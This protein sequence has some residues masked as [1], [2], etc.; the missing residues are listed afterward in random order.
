MQGIYVVSQKDI[1][2]EPEKEDPI[3]ISSFPIDSHDCQRIATADGAVVNEGTI[4]P[5]RM[6]GRRHGYPYQVPYRSILPKPQECDNL[7]VPVALSCTHVAIS[8]IRVEPTWMIL[9]QSAGIA[10][11]LA[12]GDDVAVQELPYPK[13][14]AQLLAAGQV[15]ELPELP[16]LPPKPKEVG[17][18]DPK[19]LGG[20]VLDDAA[21]TLKGQWLR[22]TNFK[23]HVG[24]G[25][26]HDDHR[27]DGKSVATFRFSAPEAGRYEVRMAYSA[28][29][30]RATKVPVVVVS[31]DNQTT[32]TVDQTKALPS[33]KLFRPI[34]VVELSAG[35]STITVSNTGG[36]GFVILDAFQ[37]VP[38]TEE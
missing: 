1:L 7:L 32:L 24:S 27:A 14:R 33:G 34:G 19:T 6:S 5:V 21:A 15:L 28:H 17:G 3:A 30:T 18:V 16:P 10:A 8:S 9:G 36:D 22:S 31:G 12:A 35:E 38:K 20:I 2:K 23:P 37:L 13:L 29:E 25:Y 26:V 11:A 4:F